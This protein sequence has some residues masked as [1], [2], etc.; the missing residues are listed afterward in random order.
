MSFEIV[1]FDQSPTFRFTAMLGA[2]EEF[3]RNNV[4]IGVISDPYMFGRKIVSVRVDRFGAV[5]KP[6]EIY[7]L[8]KT[9]KRVDA[10]PQFARNFMADMKDA[11]EGAQN[12]MQTANKVMI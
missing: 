10:F 2:M 1:G 9:V 11:A 6:E 12:E 5:F 8:D 7:R 4:R 3:G